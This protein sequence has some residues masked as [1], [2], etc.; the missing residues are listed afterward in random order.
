MRRTASLT[1]EAGACGPAH[2]LP[3]AGL[4]L[5]QSAIPLPATDTLAGWGCTVKYPRKDALGAVDGR[6]PP[7][8]QRL[9]DKTERVARS[10]VAGLVAK[11]VGAGQPI[12]SAEIAREL[13]HLLARSGRKVAREDVAAL[14][15]AALA[16]GRSAIG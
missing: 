3:E 14:V 15:N 1:E 13:Y 2:P 7:I 12:N 6:P 11:A 8:V 9:N 4:P 5:L 16:S 10:L